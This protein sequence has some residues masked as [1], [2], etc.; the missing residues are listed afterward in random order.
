MANYILKNDDPQYY[1]VAEDV[2]VY[3]DNTPKSKKFLVT[4]TDTDMGFF[5][6][7]IEELN[8]ECFKYPS[9]VIEGIL[10]LIL[11]EDG[12]IFVVRFTNRAMNAIHLVCQGNRI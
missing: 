6:V 11:P 5:P 4:T 2:V 12:E 10:S 3:Y 1:N 8:G 7:S 9:E